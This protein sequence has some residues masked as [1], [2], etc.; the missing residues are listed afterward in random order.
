M[1]SHDSFYARRLVVV[2]LTSGLGISLAITPAEASGLQA[3]VDSEAASVSFE[4]RSDSSAEVDLQEAGLVVDAGSA[5]EGDAVFENAATLQADE[6]TALSPT[7]ADDDFNLED[8]EDPTDNADNSSGQQS[9]ALLDSDVDDGSNEPVSK[10]HEDGWFLNSSGS[11]DYYL[12][13]SLVVPDRVWRVDDEGIR[14]YYLNGAETTADLVWYEDAV[15]GARYWY[16]NGSPVASHA[17][18]SPDT[19]FWYWADADGIVACGKDVFIPR[20]ESDRSAGGKWVRIRDDYSMVKGEEYAL[21]KDDSQ[22]HWWFFDSVTG[23]MLKNFVYVDSNGGKWV[24]Y[25]DIYGWMLYGEQYKQTNNESSAGYHWY[26]FD[27]VTGSTTYG[28]KW[29][30]NDEKWVYYQPNVG[31][32]VHGRQNINGYDYWFDEYTGASHFSDPSIASDSQ[33]RVVESAFLTPSPG[34]GLCAE[35]IMRLM[36]RAGC[37][38]AGDYDADDMYYAWCKSSDLSELKPGMIIA[39]PSHTHTYMGGLY[40]H[41]CVYVGNGTVMDNV[42]YVRTSSLDWWLDW[43][44]T[45]SVPQ[46]GWYRNIALV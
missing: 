3:S 22:W 10:S 42:G 44:H 43:Y 28:W 15:S 11:Y 38:Y 26:Y 39:V 7:V 34:G 32:M 14:H 19:N 45:N 4:E 29:I 23:E 17:F 6:L 8:S 25:D 40:G 20:D 41:V 16:E 24:Y 35:W 46:W 37:G 9:G 18:Y 21:S 36:N 5:T 2:A 33:R 27:D 31:W 1:V 12:N 13:G 30:E